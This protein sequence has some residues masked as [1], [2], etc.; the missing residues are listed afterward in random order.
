MLTGCA[1]EQTLTEVAFEAV[2]LG[3]EDTAAL[4][5]WRRVRRDQELRPGYG[6]GL[7][8]RALGGLG[9]EPVTFLELPQP[10]GVGENSIP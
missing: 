4:T 6:V 5:S 1:F 9:S 3:D 8:S 7:T 10:Q 2:E